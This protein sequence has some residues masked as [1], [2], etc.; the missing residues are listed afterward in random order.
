[1]DLLDIG[2]YIKIISVVIDIFLNAD[3][4]LSEF[5]FE[6][7]LE[8][9]YAPTK[10]DEFSSTLLSVKRKSKFVDS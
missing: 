1:M 2:D 6:V 7:P 3:N 9:N 4:S 5:G 10:T 8:N